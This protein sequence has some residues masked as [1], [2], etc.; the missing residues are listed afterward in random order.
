MK[1]DRSMAFMAVIIGIAMVVC[2]HMILN[3]ES[4]EER[5]ERIRFERELAMKEVEMMGRFIPFA[6]KNPSLFD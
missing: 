5:A 3:V 6:M 2:T 1:I 4:K